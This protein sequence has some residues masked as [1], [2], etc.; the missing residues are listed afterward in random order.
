VTRKES[1]VQK[2]CLQYL[3]A[4]DYYIW[5]NNTRVVNMIG[6]GGRYR[7]ISFGFKGSA[8]IIGVTP[9]GRFL[10]VECKRPLGPR[11]GHNGS[12]QS[13]DQIE[14]EKEVKK[15]NGIYLMVR[16]LDDLIAGLEKNEQPQ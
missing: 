9:T 14:F 3:K 6:A 15:R 4:A 12:K 1:D 11:G 13:D 8:D 16:S 2:V 10:A 7:P 5:R